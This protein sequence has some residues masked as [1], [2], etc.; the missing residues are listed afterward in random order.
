MKLQSILFYTI[1]L[2]EA[3]VQLS[4]I[5]CSQKTSFSTLLIKFYHT[6]KQQ[7][8]ANCLCCP[9]FIY[10]WIFKDFTGT[11]ETSENSNWQQRAAICGAAHT[12]L[13]QQCTVQHSMCVNAPLRCVVSKI[14][15]QMVCHCVLPAVLVDVIIL[16]NCSPIISVYLRCW[17]TNLLP[18]VAEAALVVETRR[19]AD[20]QPRTRRSPP[21][22]SWQ[23]LVASLPAACSQSTSSPL[24]SPP[25]SGKIDGFTL[26]D[27]FITYSFVLDRWLRCMTNSN[28]STMYW[29]FKFS[30]KL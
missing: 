4:L 9:P 19:E 18:L 15:C 24:L 21:A 3:L 29:K 1:C 20:D 30:C 7:V 12:S 26:V 6:E 22:E 8:P 25:S 23:P 10:L 11:K 28:C 17:R 2:T 13:W 16:W 14:E 5:G 27:R